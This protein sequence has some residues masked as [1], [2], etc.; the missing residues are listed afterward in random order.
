MDTTQK[1]LKWPTYE[2]FTELVSAG[3][4]FL[5]DDG[6]T[7]VPDFDFKHCCMEHDYY[8]VTHVIS[9]KEADA[10]LRACIKKQGWRLLPGIYWLG[11][12]LFGGR[13]W[14]KKFNPEVSIPPEILRIEEG[15][16]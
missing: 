9:K 3:K 10:R 11:V 14:N 1:P 12:K 15:A 4:A 8:Y 6:C 13:H 7:A 16:L 2:K 5:A